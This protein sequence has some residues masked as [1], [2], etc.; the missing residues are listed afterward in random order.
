MNVLINELMQ[1]AFPCRC[2]LCGVDCR[3]TNSSLCQACLLDLPVLKNVCVRC[4]IHLP[5]S[6]NSNLVC[7]RCLK[8]P[9]SFDQVTA[10]FHYRH[11]IKHFVQQAKFNEQ[12]PYLNLIGQL[13]VEQ[14]KLSLTDK[15]DMLIPVPLHRSRYLDRGFNQ[16][17]EMAALIAR[18]LQIPLNETLVRRKK[19][20][21]AQVGLTAKE[22]QKNVRGIFACDAPLNDQHI[23]IIDDVM[24]SGSTVNE[25][26]RILKKSQAGRVD[27][28]VFAR[29]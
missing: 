24:T 25:L 7:G 1:L 17:R 23:A 22:R 5:A 15:P 6:L 16:S 3:E 27:V 26:A 20:S 4:S 28:W 13:L 11:L 19:N 8:S 18:E 2:I 9:P 14:L 29:A 10:V 21:Q 12:L